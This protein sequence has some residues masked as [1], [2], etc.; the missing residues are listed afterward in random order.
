MSEILPYMHAAQE[1][2]FGEETLNFEAPMPELPDT[3][4][5]GTQEELAE[6]LATENLVLEKYEDRSDIYLAD[7]DDGSVRVILAQYDFY[8]AL[9][10]KLLMFMYPPEQDTSSYQL[11][12]EET[13]SY[14]C[15][16]WSRAD[17]QTYGIQVDQRGGWYL[18][19]QVSWSEDPTTEA[20]QRAYAEDLLKKLCFPDA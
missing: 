6:I 12:Y 5:L 20:A 13:D 18:T 8:T 19:V 14:R 2:G 3:M 16:S 1:L 7:S 11:S 17:Q 10:L 15:L 4:I 9:R